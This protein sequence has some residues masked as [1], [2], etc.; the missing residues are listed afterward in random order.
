MPLALALISI[1]LFQKSLPEI[2]CLLIGWRLVPVAATT[3]SK[4]VVVG[5]ALSLADVAAAPALFCISRLL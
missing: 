1:E 3:V 5:V 4:M 2:G